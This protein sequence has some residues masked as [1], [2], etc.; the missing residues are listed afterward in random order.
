VTSLYRP[1]LH[2]LGVRIVD[3]CGEQLTEEEVLIDYAAKSGNIF[4]T[5]RS[6]GSTRTFI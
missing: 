6:I 5:N 2:E 4:Q 1:K 3:G